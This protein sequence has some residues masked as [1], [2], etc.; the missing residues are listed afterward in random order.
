MLIKRPI[1]LLF[2]MPAILIYL[3]IFLYP[4]LRA[5]VMSFF[6]IPA[7]TSGISEWTYIG[8]DNYTSLFH[9][10]Y[11]LG[12]VWNVLAIWLVGGL[13]IFFFAFLFAGILSSGV[14]GKS[15]WRS[16]IFLPNTV[17]AVVMSVIWLQ[18][19]F[20]SNF[21]FLKT[22]FK[23][24]GLKTLAN[25]QWTDNEHIF[26]S[27][28]IAYSFGSIG[29]FM[30]ILL[31]GMERIPSDY[32]EA[33]V[34]EGANP[35]HKFFRITL[36][37]LRDVFRTTLVLWTV[38]AINFFVWS[39]TFGLNNPHTI[40]PGYYMYLRVF[41]SEKSVYQQEA[42]NVGSGATVGVLITL[43]IIVLSALI[44]N[45]FFRKERLEY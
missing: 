20:S 45:L 10:S 28:L 36:P 44:N 9:N 38:T 35:L 11:F 1:I 25:V 3:A 7:L 31:A 6:T 21:G 2:L 13:L 18:Y 24:V 8:F 40:T 34:L 39:A 26:I 15:F 30:L 42:F 19:I 37:L 32:Y 33:A 41:G 5:A 14:R 27:M 17:S 4:T 29:Y 23:S 16:L 43:A 12:S 22:I